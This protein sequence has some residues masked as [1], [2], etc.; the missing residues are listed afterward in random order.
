MKLI[1]DRDNWIRGEGG[2]S[3]RLC[4]AS[5][6]KMC[7]VGMLL[8]QAGVPKT[9]LAGR[10]SASAVPYLPESV[11]W[12]VWKLEG[13]GTFETEEATYLYTTNDSPTLPEAEREDLLRNQFAKQHV[14]VEFV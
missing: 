2:E 11:R 3:G 5:D 1:I 10:R 8:Q 7:P 6:G 13:G 12:L 4:R 9:A 14:E